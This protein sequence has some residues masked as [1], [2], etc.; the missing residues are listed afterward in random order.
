MLH[1]AFL[2]RFLD[3]KKSSVL[4][5]GSKNRAL[6]FHLAMWLLQSIDFAEAAS[7]S[8]V[9]AASRALQEEAINVCVLRNKRGSQIDHSFISWSKKVIYTTCYTDVTSLSW[10]V[11]LVLGKTH[12]HRDLED[13]ELV[14]KVCAGMEVILNLQQIQ[15][16]PPKIMQ[17]MLIATYRTFALSRLQSRYFVDMSYKM[18]W[19]EPQIFKDF[20]S[21]T[22]FSRAEMIQQIRPWEDT[23]RSGPLP[24]SMLNVL[25]ILLVVLAPDGVT[26]FDIPSEEES[27]FQPIDDVIHLTPR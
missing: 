7:L 21:D 10:F 17:P 3:S 26:C 12:Q 23:A 25:K 22:A 1:S 2:L 11:T 8:Y 15:R 14:E 16:K 4:F 24:C 5:L 13:E 9:F 20:G 19:R 18:I 6:R 27:E